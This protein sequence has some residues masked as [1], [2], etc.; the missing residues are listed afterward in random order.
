MCLLMQTMSRMCKCCRMC[1]MRLALL[2]ASAWVTR[3]RFHSE[4]SGHAP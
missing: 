4:R 3:T 2:S 1:L